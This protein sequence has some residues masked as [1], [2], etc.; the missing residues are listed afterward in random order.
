[1]ARCEGG[2]LTR[3]WALAGAGLALLGAGV[4]LGATA[5]AGGRP[6]LAPIALP[7]GAAAQ[8]PALLDRSVS[9]IMLQ[10]RGA[11]VVRYEA[12]AR[13][14]GRVLP[15]RRRRTIRARLAV[16]QRALTPRI[17]A[18]GARI[19]GRYRDAYYGIKVLATPGQAAA[20]GRLP[21]VVA[22]RRMTPLTPSLV[23]SVPYIGTPAAWGDYGLTGA[24]V[25]IGIIDTGIDYYHADLGGSGNPADFAADDGLTIGTPAFPNS[26]VAG[27]WDFAGDAYT[28]AANSVP[29]PDPD[30]LDCEGHGTHVAGIAAGNGV[31]ADGTPYT[32]P[33]DATTPSRSFLV[34]PGVAPQ[35]S[36]YAYRVFGCTGST[37]EVVDAVD[38]AVADG[39]NVINLSLGSP[40]GGPDDPDAVALNNAAAAGITVVSSAGN[41]GPN[42][43]TVGG[44]ST[45]DRAISVASMDATPDAPGAAV[46]GP[47]LAGAQA[48][49]INE[50]AIPEAG[51]TG[52]L[53]VLRSDGEISPGCAATD[54]AAVQPGD[55]VVTRRGTCARGDRARLGAAAGAAAV[56]MVNDTDALAPIDGPIQGVAVPFLGV[57]ASEGA[58]LMAAD[59]TPVTV[60]ATPNVANPGFGALSPFSSGGPRTGDSALKPDVTAPGASIASAGIGLG[61]GAV[62]ESGTSMAAPHVAGVAALVTQ[63]HPDWSPARIKAAIMGTA[64]ADPALLRGAV[65]RLA[66]AGL[67]QPRRAVDTAA[68]VSAGDGVSSLSF[69]DVALDDA[70]A[71]GRTFT[72]TNASAAPITYD[73]ATA[74]D[75]SALGATATVTP[76]QLVVPAGGSATA[77]L[78]LAF[79][80]AAVAALPPARGDPGALAT[81]SGVVTATP[82]TAGA[83]IYPLRVPFLIA[84]RGL[85][86][87]ATGPVAARFRLS[88]TGLQKQVGVAN[89][90]LHAGQADLFAWGL[91]DPDEGLGEADVRSVGVQVIPGATPADTFLQ[92]AIN[93]W[94]RW[95]NPSALEFDIAID[96]N[97]DGVTDRYVVGADL[98]RVTTGTADGRMASFVYTAQGTPQEAFFAD[99]PMNGS[100]LVLPARASTLGLSGGADARVTYRV[101]AFGERP[102]DS[103][104]DTVTGSASF[105]PFAPA[106]SQ[107]DLLNLAPGAAGVITLEVDPARQAADPALGWLVVSQDDAGGAA[108]ADQVPV[109]TVPTGPTTG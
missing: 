30:P 108:Q 82:T 73:L 59:G 24:G 50:A 61:S 83:G 99:A 67:V 37:N 10:L 100:T 38:R 107:G 41:E 20:L 22:A 40:F 55:I 70:A 101:T 16:R 54:Y 49:V 68:T 29:A 90:G 96:T 23:Q 72:V 17:R 76:A 88:P 63:A 60:T 65:V 28:G 79:D 105:R 21:G 69:G 53:R 4:A 35:A 18:T 81:V 95:S 26:R 66:G 78:T 25:K 85:S 64:T 56:L 13:R 57:T 43:Y 87:I 39:M 5:G 103:A 86:D 7:S 44:P 34:G 77:T 31:L 62:R 89:L 27:G 1:M 91:G 74:F 32:G 19:I 45:A 52:T 80:A 84:P 15:A 47:D 2:S 8:K 48:T 51:I 75:G 109:G 94:H 71:P 36:I 12:A 102:G 42:A 9:T 14:A 6:P 58:T 11:P 3:R 33:Y 92:F 46:S 104:V 98:G 97:G 93:T 106:V